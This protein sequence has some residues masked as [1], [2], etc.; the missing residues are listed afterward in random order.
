MVIIFRQ[1]GANI[2]STVDRHPRATSA[3]SGDHSARYRYHDCSGSHHHHRA[4]VNDAEMTVL[5]SISLVILVVF[6]F[7]RN[8]RATLIPGIA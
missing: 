2:I 8:A 3:Y 7:L 4:S 6:V 5:I 1:P